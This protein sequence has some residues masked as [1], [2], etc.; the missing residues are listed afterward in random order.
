MS[1]AGVQ[2]AAG[3]SLES[4]A[5]AVC[6]RCGAPFERRTSERLCPACCAPLRGLRQRAG[7][8]QVELA[9]RV[10]CS[11]VAIRQLERGLYHPALALAE[12][13]ARELSVKVLDVFPQL[14]VTQAEARR[15][16]QMGSRRVVELCR[17][18]TLPCV[19]DGHWHRIDYAAALRRAA[20]R[21]E[22]RTAWI[23]FRAA[24][25]EYHVPWWLLAILEQ[26]GELN[27]RRDGRRR[28]V[29]RAELDAVLTE[30]R[31]K[32]RHVRCPHCG[33]WVKL[34]RLVHARCL[35]PLGSRAYWIECD[36]DER[37]ARQRAHG[38]RMRRA[39]RQPTRD[40]GRWYQNRYGRELRGRARQRL[41]GRISGSLGGRKR[42]AAVDPTY[43]QK[44]AE[45]RRLRTA[46]PRLGT[47]EIARRTGLSR[48]QVRRILSP[49]S[50]S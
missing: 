13:I 23:S 43:E 26:A 24:E 45:A 4:G 21:A 3:L 6:E 37:Q 29:R 38:A 47:P 28:M 17:D 36:P 7:L 18:G 31:A 11:D 5:D 22:L 41:V 16:L 40:V 2:P 14:A 46:N 33:R 12:R 8:T 50:A 32:R 35:G 10:G 1:T 34:G 20:E 15:L 30:L 42:A 48:W 19:A 49:L 27:V 9:S 44:A 39:L 25:L